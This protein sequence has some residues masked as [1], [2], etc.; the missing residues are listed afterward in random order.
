MNLANKKEI[1]EILKKYGIRLT[2]GLGQN[3]L[4]NRN[5]ILKLIRLSGINKSDAVLEIGPGIGVLTQELAK[6]SDFVIAVEKDRVLSEIC[7]ENLKDFNNVIVFNEDIL[8]IDLK[9]IFSDLSIESYKLVANLPYNI[10]LRVIR[11]FL[12]YE[13]PPK[14]MIVI[15]QKEVAQKICDKKSSLPRIAFDFYGKS[16]ILFYLSKEL[17]WPKP[18]V[19]GAV[20]HIADIQKNLPDVDREL[21]FKILKFGFSH[22]RK[23]IVNNLSGL[24]DKDKIIDWIEKSNIDIK[25]RPEDIKM[26]E[27]INL[28]LNFKL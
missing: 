14:D 20:L 19:D 24:G 11:E 13:F 4:I 10:S 26:E 15:I 6:N 8:K 27:W 28:T 12:E 17:F 7:K 21:F 2:K 9:K 18:K 22:P 23:T 1:V 16:K 3:F 25:V 5:I